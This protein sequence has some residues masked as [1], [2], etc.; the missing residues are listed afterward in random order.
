LAVAVTA[1]QNEAGPRRTASRP[2]ASI[3]AKRRGLKR[4][5]KL[6]PMPDVAPTSMP[7]PVD[8]VHLLAL[9]T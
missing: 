4:S 5:R 6:G 8:A 9:L 7:G 3:P 1:L 2:A